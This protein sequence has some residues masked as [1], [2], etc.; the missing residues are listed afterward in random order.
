M[1][2]DENFTLSSFNLI[3]HDETNRSASLSAVDTC[4]YNFLTTLK[5]IK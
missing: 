4:Q 2:E 1:W 3:D 5:R